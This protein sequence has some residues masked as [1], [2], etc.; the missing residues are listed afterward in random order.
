MNP[1]GKQRQ[2]YKEIEQQIFKLE[3][4]ARKHNIKIQ[5]SLSSKMPFEVFYTAIESTR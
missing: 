2:S 5:F 4:K 3:L 1:K